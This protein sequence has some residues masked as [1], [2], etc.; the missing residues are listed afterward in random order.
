MALVK[1]NKKNKFLRK[2][3]LPPIFRAPRMT[4]PL[5]FAYT[6]YA[7][8][9]LCIFASLANCLLMSIKNNQI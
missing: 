8:G 5:T 3:N 6:A 9:R 1:K 7:Q 4:V 2:K